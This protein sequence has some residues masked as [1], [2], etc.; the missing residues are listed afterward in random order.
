MCA[1]LCL[2][3]SNSSDSSEVSSSTGSA[4]CAPAPPSCC[5]GATS[6]VGDAA[7]TVVRAAKRFPLLLLLVKA[8]WLACGWATVAA[9]GLPVAALKARDTWH[10]RWA[11]GP[12]ATV[13][14]PL[15]LQAVCTRLPSDR[16]VPAP[17]VGEYMALITPRFSP[18]VSLNPPSAVSSTAC[19]ATVPVFVLWVDQ[20]PCQL[21]SQQ[22]AATMR[23]C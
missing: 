12:R 1:Q 23:V 3:R 11:V 14:A 7:V 5:V 6:T 21:L 19:R 16:R 8:R 15:Q 22:P 20:Q 4:G 18:N 17:S 10:W 9:N 13:C 2:I